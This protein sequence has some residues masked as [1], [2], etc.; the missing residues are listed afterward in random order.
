[1]TGQIEI[2]IVTEDLQF[3]EGPIAMADGSVLLV[4]MRRQTLT[5]VYSDGKTEIVAELGGGPNGAAIGP[6]GAAYICNNGG[7]QWIQLPNGI[8]APHGTADDY[9]TGSI[10]RVQLASGKVETV[11]THCGGR[12]IRGPNDLIFD[13][14]GNFW[15]TDYGKDNSEYQEFGAIFYAKS[16]GSS[17]SLQ[18]DHLRNPNGIGLSADEKTLYV[19]ETWS[20]RL[21]AM[22][23]ESP[24][25]LAPNEELFSHGKVITTLPGLQALDSLA[26]QEDGK[27]CVANI[28]NSGVTV[29]DPDGSYVHHP[30]PD[31]ATTNICFGGPDMRTAWI[32][33]SLGGKLYKA[34]WPKAGHR[35][36]FNA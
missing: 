21:W 26:L 11:Y 27:I 35:L 6:D 25:V 7:F 17:I 1:M 16:D 36:N 4:E 28:I 13:K 8:F 24:G 20:A 32:T 34:R 14:A 5:R 30:V 12:R 15:F 2:E 18:R 9:T 31:P 33:G 23:I 3:P 29:F 22:D 10:Q 19:A